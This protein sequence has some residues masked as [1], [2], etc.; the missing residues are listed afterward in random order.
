MDD[1]NYYDDIEGPEEELFP[2]CRHTSPNSTLRSEQKKSQLVYHPKTHSHEAF[3]RLVE[4]RQTNQLCD[5]VIKIGDLTINAH[6]VI[7]SACSPYFNA[8][9]SGDMRESQ[10]GVV[11]I[12]GFNPNALKCLIE[13]CYNSS[14]VIDMTNVQVILPAAN[15]L[16]MGGVVDACCSFLAGQ[17]ILGTL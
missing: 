12:K 3:E 6:R 16:E 13:F 4:M 14:I 1:E 2:R 17:R 5:V 8:M 7:L 15:L 9:F 11:T 10:Q